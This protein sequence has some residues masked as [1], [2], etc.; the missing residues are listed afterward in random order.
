MFLRTFRIYIHVI[1]QDVTYRFQMR[2]LLYIP[3]IHTDVDLGDLATGIEERAKALLGDS[4]MRKHKEIVNLY[5]QAVVDYWQ[6]KNVV[7]LK[8]FQDAM[9]TDGA[10]GQNIVKSLAD[11]GSPNYK[12]LAQLIE[13]GAILVKTEDPE[14]LKEEYFLMRELTKN[15]S[16]SESV[17][18]LQQY[19]RRKDTLLKARDASII[20]SITEHLK[21]GETGVCFLG[22]EHQIVARLPKDIEI[23]ALKDPAKVRAYSQGFRSNKGDM[24]IL[25]SYLIAPIEIGEKDDNNNK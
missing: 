6:G 24:K 11:K 17:S 19:Q 20:T 15:K 12:I 3:I 5:W 2:R 9:A 4:N 18:A 25:G 1:W 8:I 13:H 23:I 10:L 21:E 16:F 22:A 14:P 7:G